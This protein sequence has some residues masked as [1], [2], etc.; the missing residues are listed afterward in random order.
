MRHP[1]LVATIFIVLMITFPAQSQAANDFST[2]ED[3]LQFL[4]EAFYAQLSLN[5]FEREYQDIVEILDPYFSDDYQKQFLEENLVEIN[6]KYITFGSDFAPYYIPFFAM[7][8]Q[9]EVNIRNKKI[10]IYEFFP[11]SKE[12]PVTYG[13]HYE[14]I[15]MEKV[16]NDW[17]IT[18]Y[19]HEFN[20]DDIIETKEETKETF[21]LSSKWRNMVNPYLQLNI[22]LNPVTAF[23]NYGKL[24]LLQDENSLYA[25]FTQKDLASIR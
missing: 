12:G 7:S 4:E 15:L 8:E 11:A 6:G 9:T 22:G 10:Y 5:E 24:S 21:K 1:L 19:L 17:L 23:F 3:V 14:G 18:S 13:D 16:S 20:P 2:K 25:L